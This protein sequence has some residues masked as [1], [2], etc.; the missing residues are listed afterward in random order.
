MQ[1]MLGRKGRFILSGLAAVSIAV[2]IFF[3][4]LPSETGKQREAIEDPA[5]LLFA[6]IMLAFAVSLWLVRYRRWQALAV[7]LTLWA[8]FYG[9]NV[10]LNLA[11]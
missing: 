9:A 4:S 1:G 7:F 2:T 3:V 6:G 11:M 10:V 8:L 5:G